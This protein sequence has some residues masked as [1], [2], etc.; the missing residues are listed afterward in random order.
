MKNRNSKT[1]I[2]L[3]EFVSPKRLAAIF[4]FVSAVVI[5]SPG[6]AAAQSGCGRAGQRPCRVWER[7]PSCNQG[8]VENFAKDLCVAKTPCGNLNQRACNVWE[9]VPSC[10][11]GLAEY[12]GKCVSLNPRGTGVRFCNYTGERNIYLAIGQLVQ[13]GGEYYYLARGW[14]E[15]PGGGCE[16]FPLPDSYKG[17]VYAYA[18]NEDADLEWKGNT[19]FYVDWYN[20]FRLR[21]NDPDLERFPDYKMVGMS[22]IRIYPGKTV[23]HSF[24]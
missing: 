24:R 17:Y 4:I 7:I 15:I 1:R 8:T 2:Y 20:S 14:F 3:T 11:N 22:K 5:C 9:R 18:L 23:T 6:S 12:R 21:Q 10:R 16:N 19:S 13:S